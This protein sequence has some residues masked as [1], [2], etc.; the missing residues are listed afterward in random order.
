MLTRN[1]S[2][3][4]VVICAIMSGCSQP[5]ADVDAP[6]PPLAD[7]RPRLL[8][9]VV[10]DQLRGDY[11]ERWGDLFGQDGFQ[12]LMKQGSY[13][14]NCHYA[15]ATTITGCGHASL[16]TGCS[17]NR[18]GIIENE[19]F[20]RQL[21]RMIYCS[22]SEFRQ[23]VYTVPPPVDPKARRLGGTPERLSAETLGDSLKASSNGQ[24]KILAVSLKDRSACLLGGKSC[25]HAYW[26]DTPT[27]TFVTSTFYREQCPPWVAKFNRDKFSDRWLGQSW[28]RLLPNVDYTAR[29]GPDDVIGETAG[30]SKKMERTFPHPISK[31]KVRP[32]REYYEEVTCSPSGNELVLEFAKT[33]I[34]ATDIGRGDTTDLLTISFSSNDI[35]GHSFGP[36]SHEVLDITLRSDRIVADLLRYLDQRIGAGQYLLALGSDHGVCPLPEV[37]FSKGIPATRLHPDELKKRAEAVLDAKFGGRPGEVSPW[38]DGDAFPWV[39]LNHRKIEARGLQVEV[40]AQA[41]ADWFRSLPFA[42][43]A[44]LRKELE[45]PSPTDDAITKSLRLAH[46]SER[47]GD[48]AIVFKPYVI[49][50]TYATG[51]THG[52]PYSYDTH[53]PLIFFGHGIKAGKSDAVIVPQSITPVFAKAARIKPPAQC[54]AELPANWPSSTAK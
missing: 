3:G 17:P 51:T 19:W 10:F 1:L 25:E 20:D 31:G 45:T 9:L 24:A 26:F 6:P 4:I 49:S 47:T 16:L 43:R 22:S 44:L 12:R 13:F 50:Q 27:G 23:T 28:V 8:V 11:L 54:E 42:D 37:S 48:L 7:G 35:V 39:Y 38:I 2:F 21:G 18:H 5:A 15:Y 36:D 32:D 52:S 40:V 14:T 33:A 30:I 41:V 46:Y 34:A 53:V 29:S